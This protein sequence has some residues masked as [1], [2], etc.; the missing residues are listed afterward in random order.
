MTAS[1]AV[2]LYILG[3]EQQA[4]GRDTAFAPF[5]GNG[6]HCNKPHRDRDPREKRQRKWGSVTVAPLQSS[7]D[8][9]KIAAF[10]ASAVMF[11]LRVLPVGMMI[12]FELRP[13]NARSE[14]GSLPR[15]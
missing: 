13:A 6:A 11:G 10:A 7:K 1:I 8:N 9:P 12:N 15:T 5:L 3:G 14:I 2:L 4:D